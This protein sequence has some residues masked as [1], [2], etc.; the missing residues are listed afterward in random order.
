MEVKKFND[1]AYLLF[2]GEIKGFVFSAYLTE[3]LKLIWEPNFD[4]ETDVDK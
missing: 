4:L 2:T 1:V 3:D